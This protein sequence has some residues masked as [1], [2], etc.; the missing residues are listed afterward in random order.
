M[1]IF[2]SEKYRIMQHPDYDY[3]MDDLKGECFNPDVNSDINPEQ[4]KAE[5]LKFEKEVLESGVYSYSLEKAKMGGWDVIDSCCGFVGAYDSDSERYNHYIVGEMMGTIQKT[6]LQ[7]NFNSDRELLTDDDKQ[8]IFE[9][10]SKGLRANNYNLLNDR[11]FNCLGMIPYHGILGRVIKEDC[12][13]SY[14]AGQSYPDEIRTV[15][16]IIL[17]C[18]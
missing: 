5:E 12:G 8:Q 1:F 7:F 10:L 16:K 18:R 11:I 14:C 17:T 4:L 15:R 3:D 13:W 2:D 6:F 9:L